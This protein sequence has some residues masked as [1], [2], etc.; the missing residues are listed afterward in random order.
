MLMV[1]KVGGSQQCGGKM[2]FKKYTSIESFAHVYRGQDYFDQKVSVNYGAKIKMHGTNAAVRVTPDGYAFAQSRSRDITPE[3]DNAGFAAWVAET[4]DA[5]GFLTESVDEIAPE[6]DI[7]FYGEWAGKGIQKGD[8]VCQLNDKYFFVFAVYVAESETYIV[9]PAM[10]EALVPDLDQ[11]V[12]LPWDRAYHDAIDFNDAGLCES[13]AQMLT[14]HVESVGE[15]DPFIYNIFG[16]SGPGEGWV[17]TPMCN[18]GMDPTKVG[19]V[20]EYWYNRLTFKV[21][22]QAHGVKKGKAASKD[23]EIPEGVPEFVEAFVT[24]ARCEQGL[25]EIGGVAAPEKTGDFLKW[26][27]QDVKKESAAELS[28][29]MLEW[30]DVSKHVTAAARV[31]WL[32]QCSRID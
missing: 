4:H 17:L 31:W 10:I 32:K 22:T 23:L 1:K 15:R 24:P 29:M 19:T 3:Q 9:D 12:V 14:E 20:D 13:F 11:V 28:E 2:S 16:I 6:S 21:K 18:P 30:R 25:A 7:I 27:G 26:L 8:A 5:W